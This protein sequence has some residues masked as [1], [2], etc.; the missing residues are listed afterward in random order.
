[1]VDEDKELQKLRDELG[2]LQKELDKDRVRKKMLSFLE[3]VLETV[4]AIFSL[5]PF[6]CLHAD[7]CSLVGACT[8]RPSVR[9]VFHPILPVVR[10]KT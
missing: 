5:V 7:S 2:K 6:F 9:H 10:E 1:M 3:E 4:H 8:R